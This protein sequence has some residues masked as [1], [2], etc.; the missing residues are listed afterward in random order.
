MSKRTTL[1]VLTTLAF[2]G[3]CGKK[4]DGLKSKDDASNHPTVAPIASPTSGVDQLKRMNFVWG[5]EGSTAFAK[6][7]AAYKQKPRDWAAVRAHC[8][9]ALARDPHH[10]GAHWL[11]GAALAQS[12][13]HA[14]AVDHLVTAI[15]SD[16]WQYGP[17]L[18]KQDD[19]K[20]FLA[21]AHGASVTELADRIRDDYKKRT[22]TAIL[23]VGRRSSFRWPKDPGVQP[24]SSRGELYAFDRETKRYLRLT[25]TDD[26]SLHLVVLGSPHF[27]LAEYARLAPMIAG[28]KKHP[29]VKFL[30][31]SSR[32]MTQFADRAGYVQALKDFGAQITVDTCILTSPML[33][34]EIQN[35]MTNSAKFA[36]YAPGLLSKKIGFGSLQDCVDSAVAGKIIRDETAWE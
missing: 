26:D 6:A 8:E 5:S 16:Y 23:L 34:A 4:P 27:S 35:L 36:Y 29:D 19:L 33:P 31:T 21:T 25:H 9:A 22:A 7:T 2:A 20:A 1:A 32:A 30:V 15:A 17:S 28:K 12:G 24:N 3:A 11:L 18:P 10:L 14:A 13:D